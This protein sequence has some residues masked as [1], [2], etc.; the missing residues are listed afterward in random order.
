MIT[1]FLL[2]CGGS[3]VKLAKDGPIEFNVTDETV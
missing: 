2:I 3:L 1:A